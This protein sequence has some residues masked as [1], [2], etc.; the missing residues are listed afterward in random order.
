MLDGHFPSHDHYGQPLQGVLGARA[1]CPI[2]GGWL[3][4]FESW[5]GDW[6]ERSLSHNFIKRNYQSTLL[7]DQCSAIKPHK[8]TPENLMHLVYSNFNLDAPWTST[9][10]THAEYLAQTSIAQQSPWVS[11]PGFDISRVCWD[12]AHTILLGTGKDLAASFLCDLV[13]CPLFLIVSM[14]G[15]TPQS[16]SLYG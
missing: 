13:A 16:L 12:S 3:A 14:F 15:S 8:K 2:A 6:K 5:N 11:V 4:A 1:G 9:I 7:C 10:R